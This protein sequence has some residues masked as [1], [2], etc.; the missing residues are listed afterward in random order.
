MEFLITCGGIVL[1]IAMA[2]VA[3]NWLLLFVPT[4]EELKSKEI[5]AKAKK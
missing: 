2:H 5:I 1:A 4:P 3:T